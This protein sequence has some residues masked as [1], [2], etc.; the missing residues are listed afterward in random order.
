MC[1]VGVDVDVGVVVAVSA[2][3]QESLEADSD[4]QFVTLGDQVTN[5]MRSLQQDLFVNKKEMQSIESAGYV[6]F[7]KASASG[8]RALRRKPPPV[9]C[10]CATPASSRK[11]LPP[12]PRKSSKSWCRI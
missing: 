2:E 8:R 4:W 5:R 9:R 12:T 3:D 11:A 1:D 7:S 6:V 10:S